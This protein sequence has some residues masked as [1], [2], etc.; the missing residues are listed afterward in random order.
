MGYNKTERMT[1]AALL[2][3]LQAGMSGEQ[4]MPLL[5]SVMASRDQ[6]RSM[7]Q[8]MMQQAMGGLTNFAGTAADAG[9]SNAYL[10]AL[11][12]SGMF[13]PRQ[14]N[15]LQAFNA[16]LYGADPSTGRSSLYG[17][18]GDPSR[19]AGGSNAIAIT[20]LPDAEL[21]AYGTSNPAVYAQ[22]LSIAE[23]EDDPN[24]ILR[25]LMG[26]EGG[27][28]SYWAATNPEAA[29]ATVAK[30]LGLNPDTEQ[31]NGGFLSGL[32][33][34][35]IPGAGAYTAA[36]LAGKGVNALSGGK[37]PALASLPTIRGGLGSL[38]SKLPFVGGGAAAAAP[39]AAALGAQAIA[40]AG[41]TGIAATAP[42]LGPASAW[43]GAAAAA[44]AA[45]EAA[46]GAGL[47]ST[48]GGLAS[49]GYGIPLAVLIG[50]LTLGGMKL[51][52]S[53]MFG[54]NDGEGIW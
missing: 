18:V 16:G 3:G 39:S 34:A 19:M 27:A 45:G 29:R 51:S 40:D 54:M 6:R 9:A 4:A 1:L 28:V 26:Q 36:R 47:A 17:L 46:T 14:V 41:A 25:K 49:T 31:D 12:N 10:Q 32:L 37:L 13:K 30:V 11:E 5:S 21:A 33:G 44:T 42:V 2:S 8:D 52:G 48:L 20:G 50:A 53:H 43:P 7:N 24:E 23:N 22:I 38:I 15:R 35:I